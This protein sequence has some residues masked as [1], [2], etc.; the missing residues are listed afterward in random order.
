MPAKQ[1][2][3]IRVEQ[4]RKISI[5]EIIYSGS[6]IRQFGDTTVELI[7]HHDG[8]RLLV[9]GCLQPV[10]WRIYER[11]IR[12]KL[13]NGGY[14]PLDKCW[15]YYI[16]GHK[17]GKRYK[18]LRL[19]FIPPNGFRIGTSSDFGAMYTTSCRS[20]YQRKPYQQC[21]SDSLTKRRR[22]RKIAWRQELSERR[23]RQ[24]PRSIVKLGVWPSV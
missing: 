24:V 10:C 8:I 2:K 13:A 6:W 3:R 9:N 5:N 12:G 17:D 18:Y 4:L 1:R 16:F 14:I 7:H 11:T 22:A 15:D 20:R 23:R 21:L 19:L